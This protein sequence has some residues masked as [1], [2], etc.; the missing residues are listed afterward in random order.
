[1]DLLPNEDQQQIA[2][3]AGDFLTAEL[4]AGRLRRAPAD[5]PA[6]VR[7][8]AAMGWLGMALPEAVGGAG[9]T[10]ADELMVFREAGRQLISPSLLA[11][12]LAADLAL[13]AGDKAL[14]G[15]FLAGRPAAF[16]HPLG[17][18]EADS[19]D[20]EF[21]LIDAGAADHVL[22]WT[23]QA[24]ALARAPRQGRQP[25]AGIDDALTYERLRLD[26]G[27]LIARSQTMGPAALRGRILAAAMLVG[28]AQATRDMAS[29]YAKVRQQFGRA[30]GGFQ[31]VKHRCAN[32]VVEAEC[33]QAQTIFAAAAAAGGREDAPFHSFAAKIMATRAS[34][35]NAR[36]NIQVHGAMGFTV[37]CDAHWYVKRSH[38]LDQLGGQARQRLLLQ[39]PAPV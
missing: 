8:A 2:E 6:E 16:A 12:T 18:A 35:A 31:A 32:M 28:M 23:A 22:V 13:S 19:L 38:V 33:A 10:V 17:E 3:V 1:M 26:G 36:S 9:L 24:I 39:C 21:L 14:A 30:I 20:R 7:A 29:E 11:T 34:F 37:E 5:G 25:G 4:P 27:S 15:E